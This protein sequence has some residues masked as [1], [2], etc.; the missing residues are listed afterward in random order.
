[1]KTINY[2]ILAED[3][4]N[5]FFI[6]AFV[7]KVLTDLAINDIQLKY[8]TDFADL[9]GR[10]DNEYVK[11]H[12]ITAVQVGTGR[13]DLDL[14]FVALD[15]DINLAKIP[16]TVSVDE[17][18]LEQEHNKL[19]QE[20]TNTASINSLQDKILISIAVQS[21]EYWFYILKIH[22]ENTTPYQQAIELIDRKKMKELVYGN[23][24]RRKKTEPV[25]KK[26]L[27]NIDFNILQQNSKS[28]EHFYNQV[29]KYL[30]EQ[31]ASKF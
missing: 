13:F 29:S 5:R 26:L 7:A 9:S 23:K 6:E 17:T 24:V 19:Y 3:A 25:V 22:Q 10:N 14:I 15:L 21:I 30:A 8:D 20:M 31:T 1:M 18:F 28:F 2:S 16:S 27:Q 4:A 12:F 11:N